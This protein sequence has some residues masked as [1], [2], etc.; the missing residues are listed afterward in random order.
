MASDG[1]DTFPASI[2]N[3]MLQGWHQHKVIEARLL[4]ERDIIER[5]H[6]AESN[7]EAVDPPECYVGL[8]DR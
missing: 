6:Q 8:Q 3:Y 5:D 4:N 1:K 7:L 2:K